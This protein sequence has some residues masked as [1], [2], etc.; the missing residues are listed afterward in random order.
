MGPELPAVWHWP[1]RV[2]ALKLYRYESLE[3]IKG[4]ILAFEPAVPLCI[5]RRP[6]RGLY[7]YTLLCINGA[8]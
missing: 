5:R 1:I 2:M 7:R 4:L 8:R 6:M 3:S